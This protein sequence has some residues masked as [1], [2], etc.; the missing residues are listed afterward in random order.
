MASDGTADEEAGE[1]GVRLDKQT[2][3]AAP[4]PNPM[5]NLIIANILLRGGGRIL[6]QL[7][8]SN[9]LNAKY[10]PQKSR[11][12]VKGRGIVGALAG[13]AIVRVATRSVPGA[14]IVGGGLLAKALY[15][16]SKGEKAKGK[17]AKPDETE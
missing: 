1:P 7:V 6:R 8:E 5:T 4:G 2:G 12:I 10:S 15:D 11:D 9:L 14:L 17:G 3:H 13:A 16:R